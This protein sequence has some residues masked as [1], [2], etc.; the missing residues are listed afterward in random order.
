MT[1]TAS[2]TAAHSEDAPDQGGETRQFVTFFVSDKE[3]GVDIQSVREIKGWQPTTALPNTPDYV[4]GALN[5]RGQIITVY[6][7][8]RRIGLGQSDIGKGHVVVVVE[9]GD[10]SLGLLADSVSD[11][12]TLEARAIR[13]VPVVGG[14]K[15]QLLSGLIPR[16]ERMVSILELDAIAGAELGQDEA[17]EDDGQMVA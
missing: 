5:L 9:I 6:D 7:L 4:I 3:F 14:D 11:I 12:I 10:R 13:P 16:D 1:A 17:A 15:E 2:E 8:G